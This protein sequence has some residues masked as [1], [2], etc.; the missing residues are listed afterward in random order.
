MYH[1]TYNMIRYKKRDE[2]RQW[3]IKRLTTWGVASIILTNVIKRG[4]V[5]T[6]INKVVYGKPSHH[7]LRFHF[8]NSVP[9]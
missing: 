5:E 7:F 4:F 8:E 2:V 9:S 6:P 1:V 3:K